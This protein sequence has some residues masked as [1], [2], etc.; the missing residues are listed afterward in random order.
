[1]LDARLQEVIQ[2]F[3][4]LRNVEQHG[5]LDGVRIAT[6]HAAP[7]IERLVLLCILFGR[8]ERVPHVGVLGDQAERDLRTASANEQGEAPDRSG[9]KPIEPGLD[10]ADSGLEALEAVRRT[11][12]RETVRPVVPFDIARSEAKNQAAAA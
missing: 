9:F 5:S 4:L 12:K 6:K 7:L 11:G 1:M 2:P 3:G 10:T 8:A